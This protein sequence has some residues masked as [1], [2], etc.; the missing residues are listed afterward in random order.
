MAAAGVPEVAG[1]TADTEV[2]V[3][4]VTVPL[5]VTPP[6]VAAVCANAGKAAAIETSTA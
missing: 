4:S 6:G 3:P 1:D 2:P 5:R